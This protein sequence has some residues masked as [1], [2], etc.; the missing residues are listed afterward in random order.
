MEAAAVAC[1]RV[2]M[3]VE[4]TPGLVLIEILWIVPAPAGD[5]DLALQGLEQQAHAQTLP[6]AVSSTP[7]GL[8]AP[9]A[10]PISH[11]YGATAVHGEASGTL[12]DRPQ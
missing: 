1:V 2:V 5:P 9:Q 11:P 7:M 8:G 12:A 6:V 3:H 10:A 4:T